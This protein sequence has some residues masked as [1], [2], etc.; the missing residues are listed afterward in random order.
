MRS[1]YLVILVVIILQILLIGPATS[2]SNDKS[3]DG[4][5]FDKIGSGPGY[6][7][8]VVD[9]KPYI[10]FAPHLLYPL[11][12]IDS[13]KIDDLKVGLLDPRDIVREKVNLIVEYTSDTE[14]EYLIE[15]I[16]DMGGK[17]NFVYKYLPFIAFEIEVG[18][19]SELIKSY[20]PMYFSV[21]YRIELNLNQSVGMIIDFNR[22]AVLE[23]TL[24]VKID[25]SGIKIAILDTGIDWTHPDFFFPNGTSKI[26]Y[27]VS[28]VPD[29][30]PYDYYGHGTHVA[31][32]A[33]GT[34]LASNGVFKGVAPGA[35]LMNI[36]V[37]SSQGFGLTSWI[38]AGI[39]EAV[40]N[41]ADVI[42]L[43]LGGG[44]NGDGSDPLS[45]AVDWAVQQGVVVV[46][47]AGNDGPNY[48]SLGSPGVSTLAITVGA[49]D[50]N[51]E[52]AD[53]SS[54]GPTGDLRVKP[55][56]LAPGVDII[57]PLAKDSLLERVLGDSRIEGSGGD[58]ISLS[59]TSMATPHVAGVAALIL[60]VRPDM[61]A[62]D[63]KNLIVSTADPID[64]DIFSYGTGLVNAVDALNASLL[65]KNVSFNVNM[66][67]VFSNTYTANITVL[68]LDGQPTNL[69]VKN[70]SMIGFYNPGFN[71][72]SSVNV[73]VTDLNATVKRISIEIP[74]VTDQ[75][76][77]MG[78]IIFG[79]SDDEEYQL[80]FTAY[81]LFDVY[82]NTTY[83]GEVYFT[84]FIAYDSVNPD[85]WILPT[86]GRIAS[87]GEA[88]SLWFKL[89]YG[90]YK[91][92]G[93]SINS[94]M[95]EDLLEG[96]VTLISR[97]IQ[98]DRDVFETI[99]VSGF[100]KVTLPVKYRGNDLV[101]I[102]HLYGLYT[103]QRDVATIY[104]YGVWNV[105]AD[106]EM[107]VSLETTDKVYL[108][109]QYL[110]VPYN[111]SGWNY[112]E[113]LDYATTYIDSSW[114]ISQASR[115]LLFP[116]LTSFTLDTGSQAGN[117]SYLGG[118]AVFPP[119][120]SFTFLVLG[121]AYQGASYKLLVSEDIQIAG[122][123]ES[124]YFLTFNSNGSISSLSVLDTSAI[125]KSL[126]PATPPYFLYHR[127]EKKRIAGGPAMNITTFLLSDLEPVQIPGPYTTEYKLIYNGS[128]VDRDVSTGLPIVGFDN[129]R[130]LDLPYYLIVN[131]SN[132]RM[133]LFSD[134]DTVFF[135]NSSQPDPEPPILYGLYSYFMGDVI[136]FSLS[137][138]E[139]FE[140]ERFAVYVSWDGRGFREVTPRLE[141][142][143]ALSTYNRY[144]Y[145]FSVPIEGSRLDIKLFYMD[146]YGNYV[147]TIYRNV[148]VRQIDRY[149][150]FPEFDVYPRLLSGDKTFKIEVSSESD[151]VYGVSLY[152]NASP[153]INIPVKGGQEIFQFS[154]ELLGASQYDIVRFNVLLS[155]SP[156]VPELE[157]RIG[158][159]VVYTKYVVNYTV[160]KDRFSLNEVGQ[161]E[162]S[163]SYLHNGSPASPVELIVNGSTYLVED[164]RLVIN[165][166]MD[167]PGTLTYYVEDARYV[168][169]YINVTDSILP[170]EPAKLVFDSI[171][172]SYLGE[173][174]YRVDVTESVSIRYA[175]R[176]M[177]DSTSVKGYLEYVLN[178]EVKRVDLIDGEAVIIVSSDDVG[179]YEVRP[180][181]VVDTEYNITSD[182]SDSPAIE[183]VFDRVVIE[184]STDYEVVQVGR[185]I[186]IYVNAY[187]AY[188]GTPFDGQVFIEPFPYTKASPGELVF[189]VAGIVDNKYGLTR[190]ISN[191][192]GVYFD[193]L[194]I[195]TE[196]EPSLGMVRVTI[197]VYFKSL[198]RPVDTYKINDVEYSGTFTEEI[199]GFMIQFE[200]TYTVSVPGFDDVTI[201]VQ[202]MNMY[203]LGVLLGGILAL[204]VIA[205]IMLKRFRGSRA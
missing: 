82:L 53:F 187:Y 109:I 184:L 203:N 154:K 72:T 153:V 123:T 65:F 176:H 49:V 132:T 40:A 11:D 68:D 185:E 125:S 146:W 14:K 111:V 67:K 37:L 79:T 133:N 9:D 50:K 179:R 95:S 196:V 36:K 16:L 205:F 96:P 23:A 20:E 12:Y 148:Y 44:L 57:A 34:G 143:E 4:L 15:N 60:Q 33:A 70:I 74:I 108:N 115:S 55:D 182:L 168:D 173:D 174:S 177:L 64:S 151:Y 202:T 159:Q 2:T 142:T 112:T 121:P 13:V 35:L 17:I 73:D 195:R 83:N 129:L 41:G 54:R 32:I 51:G 145:Q 164:G 5:R 128:I 99:E 24:A 204:A 87:D 197:D 107:Y 175:F 157:K 29:E 198:G 167:S 8:I 141:S 48:G 165:V 103:P 1:K 152:I 77:Y 81:R 66:R 43:S 136:D 201:E 18:K 91:F 183:V 38:I 119:H 100:R 30:D 127:V 199:G 59:G 140:L 88:Y 71:L 7:I 98:L 161:V 93:V 26:V 122:E 160:A 85:R 178:D 6:A 21:D 47:A 52:I 118:F 113:I 101:P 190:F 31:G 25:G 144:N 188:D 163:V 42:N 22:L 186:N 189:K 76:L 104:Q 192:I 150:L 58:Y 86:G 193:E 155:T 131:M 171:D 19:V 45:K 105:S 90:T 124:K 170:V 120:Q 97:E 94:F 10:A 116:R 126:N 75:D 28:M 162:F 27:N 134:I 56:V 39:E 138:L 62:L 117:E 80:V 106:Y 46:A 78:R 89:P 3:L 114:I 149:D 137:I 180:L 181:R 166:T 156:Y 194:D 172:V 102:G 61:S 84:F 200:K 139:G 110:Q 158:F 147:E 191:E 130:D 169:K 135:I 69:Y 92:I 63:V